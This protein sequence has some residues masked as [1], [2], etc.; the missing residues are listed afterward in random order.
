MASRAKRKPRHHSKRATKYDADIGSRVRLKR[1]ELKMSQQ[2]LG[3]SLG[4]SFQQI[5][6]YETGANRISAA[7]VIEIC[8]VLKLDPNTLLGWH[9]N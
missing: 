4:V 6:K 1:V 3:N 8:R 2:E 9:D 7:R 5:Q